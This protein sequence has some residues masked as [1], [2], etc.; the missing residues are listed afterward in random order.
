M[1]R[2]RNY[3]IIDVSAGTLHYIPGHMAHRLINTGN[4]T[5]SVGA[6]W[7][8]DSG[9][10]YDTIKNDGFSVRIFKDP[11]QKYRIVENN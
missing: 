1:D 6:C 9:Y 10:D 11:N 5:L 7:C 2:E 8:S 3:Q 4:E